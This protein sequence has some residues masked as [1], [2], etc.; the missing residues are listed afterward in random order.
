M[1]ILGLDQSTAKTGWAV[2]K[3]GELGGHGNIKKPYKLKGMEA[4]LYQRDAIADLLLCIPL[5]HLDAIAFESLH[6]SKQTSMDV[7]FLLGALRGMVAAL[8][9]DAGVRYEFV[10]SPEV[11]AYIDMPPNTDRDTKK[12]TTREIVAMDLFQDRSRWKEIDED[13]ADAIAIGM[14]AYRRL[15][16]ESRIDSSTS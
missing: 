7:I 16:L 14:I 10:S 13:E 11:C 1:K 15:L 6:K 3:D 2:I 5:R 9:H 4:A 12:K 8:A